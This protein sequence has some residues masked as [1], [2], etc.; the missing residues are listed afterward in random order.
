MGLGIVKHDGC[1]YAAI[2]R[3]TYQCILH[4]DFIIAKHSNS[5]TFTDQYNCHELVYNN[6]SFHLFT[7]DTHQM[8]NDL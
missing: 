5:L 7:D 2:A 1:R 8:E 3:I 6:N 4:V